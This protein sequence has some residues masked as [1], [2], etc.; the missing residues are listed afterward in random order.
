MTLKSHEKFE[1]ELTH[2]FKNDMAN[3]VNIYHS[4]QT[5]ENFHFPGLL[6]SKVY[7]MF[8][9]KKYRGVM[10]YNNEE[11]CKIWKIKLT[12]GLE[13]DMG[14][15]VKCHQNTWKCLNWDFDGILLESDA[16]FQEELACK[17]II[18]MRSLTS[19]DPSTQKSYVWWNLKLM[20]NLTENWHVLPKMT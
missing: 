1:E 10:F 9:L 19:F 11:W 15:F 13:N 12:F 6:L 8:L 3:L 18:D 16:R 4:T 2:G 20:Q 14:N 7:I 17:F 5:S